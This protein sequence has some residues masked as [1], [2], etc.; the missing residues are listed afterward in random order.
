MQIYQAMVVTRQFLPKWSCLSYGRLIG[1]RINYSVLVKM[2]SVW[3]N[4]LDTGYGKECMCRHRVWSK[5]TAQEWLEDKDPIPLR[6]SCT[7][8]PE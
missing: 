1:D 2:G 8:T 4:R 5:L 3:D 7:Y 6:V